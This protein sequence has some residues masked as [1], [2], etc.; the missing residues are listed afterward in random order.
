MANTYDRHGSHMGAMSVVV[1][2]FIFLANVV[3]VR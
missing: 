1:M 3:N 2:S